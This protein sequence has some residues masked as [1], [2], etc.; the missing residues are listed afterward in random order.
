M[1]PH[2]GQPSDEL[3]IRFLSE[4]SPNCPV[5]KYIL[6]GLTSAR[7][8]ECGSE[9]R[10]TLQGD[11]L[12]VR[13]WIIGAIGA[14]TAFGMTVIFWIGA[15]LVNLLGSGANPPMGGLLMMFAAFAVAGVTLW[16]W[17][18]RHVRIRRWSRNKRLLGSLGCWFV[19]TVPY[20]IGWLFYFL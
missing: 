18:T 6:K 20:W 1:E 11:S 4:R 19:V 15:I 7:C 2:P 12:P 3:L 9:F 14:S 10:L 16:W 8:P 5:C 17:C 13:E